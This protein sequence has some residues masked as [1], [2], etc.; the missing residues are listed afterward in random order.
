MSTS[1]QTEAVWNAVASEREAL[2]GMLEQF[3]DNDW[4]HDTLCAGWRVRDV[5]AH[6]IQAT[7][8]TLPWI[9]RNVVRARGNLGKG[10]HETAI[11]YADSTPS[12]TLL[13]QL[14]A[15][16]DSRFTPIGTTPEDRLMDLLVHI[17]DIALPLGLD[18]EMPVEAA[19][20]S[21]DRVWTMGAP[22]HA[23][24]HFGD[25]RLIATD[26]EW[27]AGTGAVIEGTT[28]DLLLLLTGRTATRYRLRGPGADILPA[29]R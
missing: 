1:P 11:R 5:V 23:R 2:A 13:T 25:Y 20:T 17:Q 10:A 22:F 24:K 12:R 29:T 4:N 28:A 14:R 16:A 21:V 27:T 15:C 9:L 26:S 18:R 7:H 6:L 3:D 8:A 19:R